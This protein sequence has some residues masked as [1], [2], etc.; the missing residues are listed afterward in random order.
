MIPDKIKYMG[1]TYRV[2]EGKIGRDE[3]GQKYLGRLFWGKTEIRLRKNSSEQG[4]MRTLVHEIMH[5]ILGER[6]ESGTDPERLI[7][8]LSSGFVHILQENPELYEYIKEME[9]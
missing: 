8:I 1:I 6:F 2:R 4:K 7:A 3:D 5:I 9:E